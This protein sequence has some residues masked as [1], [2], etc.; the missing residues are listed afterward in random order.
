MLPFKSSPKSRTVV[1]DRVSLLTAGQLLVKDIWQPESSTLSI[2]RAISDSVVSSTD[3]LDG[4]LRNYAQLSPS[5]KPLHHIDFTPQ[6]AV[7]GNVW[8]HGKEFDVVVKGMPERII[9]HCD[10]TENER[11]SLLIRFHT[12]S[13]QGDYVIA[14][15]Q[16]RLDH[17][18]TSLTELSLNEK[19]TFVG[20]VRLRVDVSADTR[21]LIRRIQ[22]HGVHPYIVTGQHPSIGLHLGK[23]LGLAR[24]SSDIID[25]RR[26][27]A[28]DDGTVLDTLREASIITRADQPQKQHIITRLMTIDPTTV[29]ITDLDQLHTI[30]T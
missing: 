26:L 3:P 6:S 27:A 25:A 22:S 17:D 24:N 29:H 4:A 16:A 30:I 9:D 12:M 14:L 19:L 11:E 13:V 15:A 20:F 21:Q 10:L 23:Q 5:K 28:M 18:L 7:S 1:I 2:R 8:H